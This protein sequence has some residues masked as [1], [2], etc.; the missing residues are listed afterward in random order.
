MNQ[1]ATMDPDVAITIAFCFEA[2]LVAVAL[3]L[4]IGHEI[5]KS[6]SET[7]HENRRGYLEPAATP[8]QPRRPA[9][10]RT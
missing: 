3:G 9:A 8:A 2:F 10:R 6:R 4:F 7:A 5:G 1:V